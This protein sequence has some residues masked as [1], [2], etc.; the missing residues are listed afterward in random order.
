MQRKRLSVA[1]MVPI[2]IATLAIAGLAGCVQGSPAP[3]PTASSSSRSTSAAVP[4][5]SAAPT[6][7]PQGSADANH[8]YFDS[9]NQRLFAAN[10]GANG[11]AVIDNL[12]S[13]GFVKADM[14]VTP[15][16]TSINGNVDSLLF[17]VRIGK[18]CLIG[19]H[20]GGGY[21]SSVQAALAGGACLVGKTRAIDW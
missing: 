19:Q 2:L 9:V 1:V 4:T 20:G 12:V 17:S 5:T 14:Q 16:K 3:V 6:L 7:A 8:A 21:A 18:N 11:R 10:S 15:D 13:A